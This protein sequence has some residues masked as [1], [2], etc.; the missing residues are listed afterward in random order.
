MQSLIARVVLQANSVILSDSLLNPATAKQVSSALLEQIE[1]A[2]T[3]QAYPP[4]VISALQESIVQ[5]EVVS[6]TVQLRPG[7]VPCRPVN[8]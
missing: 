5:L 4:W 8:A 1:S 6:K 2:L 7:W 3:I